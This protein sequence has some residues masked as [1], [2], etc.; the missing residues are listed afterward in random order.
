MHSTSD[1]QKQS[2]CL[3]GRSR[4][5]TSY[6]VIV[7]SLWGCCAKHVKIS[8][9]GKPGPYL[10]HKR[11]LLPLRSRDVNLARLLVRAI[12][13]IV[14][15]PCKTRERIG[16]ACQQYPRLRRILAYDWSGLNRR[17]IDGRALQAS[18]RDP[19]SIFQGGTWGSGSVG[20]GNGR[21]ASE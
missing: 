3:E 11:I 6:A 4:T 9:I 18:V 10:K 16:T 15:Y 17:E 20:C 2:P 7:E 13:P 8:T 14:K 19:L 5:E 21:N 12:A 1:S